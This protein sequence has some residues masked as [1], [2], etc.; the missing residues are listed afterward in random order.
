M[1]IMHD[2]FWFARNNQSIK[3]YMYFNHVLLIIYI[4][5]KEWIK[6]IHLLI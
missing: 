5:Y 1:K 4:L 2:Y 6:Q 3:K